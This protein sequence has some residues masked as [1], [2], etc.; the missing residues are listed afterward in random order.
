MCIR[1]SP[2]TDRLYK[3]LLKESGKLA[4]EDVTEAAGIREDGYGMGLAA[5][6]YDN[7]GDVDVYVTN[8]GPNAL[9]RNNGDGTFT[10]VIEAS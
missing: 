1:D 2:K 8:F 5:G 6:D 10:D 4:F 3:N 7:D 9:W